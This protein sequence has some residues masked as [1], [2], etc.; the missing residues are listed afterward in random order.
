MPSYI[1]KQKY[2]AKVDVLWEE[3]YVIHAEDKQQARVI[4]YDIPYDDLHEIRLNKIKYFIDKKSMDEIK[5][6]SFTEV[7]EITESE[8]TE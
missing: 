4:F 5:D 2:K 7:F 6:D 1:V 8:I 3:S